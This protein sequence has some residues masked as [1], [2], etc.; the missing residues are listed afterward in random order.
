MWFIWWDPCGL[1]CYLFGW[2]TIFTVNYIV[3]VD[4]L[5][6]WVGYSLPGWFAIAAYEGLI[7]LICAAYIRAATTDPGSV[8]KNSANIEDVYPADIW[9]PK[10]RVCEK[11]VCIKPPRAHHCSVCGRCINKMDHHCPWVNNCVGSNNMKYFLQFVLYVGLG[12][13]V[14]TLICGGRGIF[15]YRY[16]NSCPEYTVY[17]IVT[18]VIATVLAIFFAIFTAT[19]FMDQY[20]GMTT[21]T[22][23]IESLKHWAEDDRSL[24]EGMADACGEACS[25]RWLLPMDIP[26]DSPSFFVWHPEHDKDAIDARD[27][28]YRAHVQ[29][30]RQL[31]EQQAAA[32]AAGSRVQQ[33]GGQGGAHRRVLHK[34]EVEGGGRGG[35]E[36]TDTV[37]T[38][39]SCARPPNTQHTPQ[40][41]VVSTSS[42]TS[43]TFFAVPQPSKR[44]T[45]A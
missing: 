36:E 23:G 16:P 11:C 20:E 42:V 15:C 14:S 31:Q 38:S 3:V 1:S 27:P 9:L 45:T 22:T 10:R 28:R 6:P 4:I 8:P 41:P 34:K 26:Y 32:Q 18:L 17:S 24:K 43:R 29:K 21:N 25:F 13:V 35:E 44:Q 19:M 37:P 30:V 12:G 2:A 7:A 33:G 5:V 40:D 39:I